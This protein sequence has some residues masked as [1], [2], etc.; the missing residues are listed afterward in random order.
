VT[1]DGSTSTF[2]SRWNGSIRSS[3]GGDGLFGSSSIFTLTE[4]RLTTSSTVFIGLTTPTILT[5]TLTRWTLTIGFTTFTISRNGKGSLSWCCFFGSSSSFSG[6]FR[7]SSSC[8]SYFTFTKF[9]LTSSGTVLIRST[10]V[11]IFTTT[12]SIWTFTIFFTTFT[13]ITCKIINV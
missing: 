5:T 9:R 13:I 8:S 11:A 3:S 10:T 4:F 12:L 2:S 6:S 1:I 7:F